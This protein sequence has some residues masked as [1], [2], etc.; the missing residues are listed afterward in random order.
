[1]HTGAV[2]HPGDSADFGSHNYSYDANGN[3]ISDSQILKSVSYSWDFEDRLTQ[4]VV[5]ALGEDP[6]TMTY[7]FDALGRRIQTN[8]RLEE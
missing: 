7:K 4:A 5:H 3:R 1:M 6:I 2:I 8:A